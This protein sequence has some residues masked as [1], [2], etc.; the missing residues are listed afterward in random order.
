MS[1]SSSS[2]SS[3]SNQPLERQGSS[4]HAPPPPDPDPDRSTSGCRLVRAAGSTQ[5]QQRRSTD[6]KAAA[7]VGA[8]KKQRPRTVHPPPPPARTEHKESVKAV[9]GLAG[10]SPSR[11]II[12]PPS[13]WSE[14]HVP[15]RG[16]PDELIVLD[17]GTMTGRRFAVEVFPTDTI[18]EVKSAIAHDQG[19]PAE[20]QVLVHR[21]KTLRDSAMVYEYSLQ[22]GARVDLILS[23]AGGHGPI[24]ASLHARAPAP[25]PPPPPL[26]SRNYDNEGEDGTAPADG[27]SVLLLLCRQEDDL[28]LL[29]LLMDRGRCVDARAQYLGGPEVSPDDLAQL[30]RAMGPAPDRGGAAP[31]SPSSDP[32][33]D[34]VVGGVDLAQLLGVPPRPA[35]GTGGLVSSGDE[36]PEVLY[37]DEEPIECPPD[38]SRTSSAT[39]VTAALL[40]HPPS[41]VYSSISTQTPTTAPARSARA[42]RPGTADSMVTLPDDIAHQFGI[43]VHDHPR[44]LA[45]AISHAVRRAQPS[46][47]LPPLARGG[48]V[49]TR[50][51]RPA[52]AITLTRVAVRPLSAGP[53]AFKVR[54]ASA[55]AAG[56][57]KTVEEEDVARQTDDSPCQVFKSAPAVQHRGHLPSLRRLHHRR[58]RSRNGRPQNH[59][60]RQ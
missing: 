24:A 38:S 20:S 31:G 51:A 21:S 7:V 2:S 16:N 47:L 54:A 13:I 37:D 48:S 46:W 39:T 14:A 5:Q 43:P 29:E 53:A 12:T 35:R 50:A 42:A 3:S 19:V 11:A 6:G 36:I 44:D 60:P 32:A 18:W 10:L 45:A 30:I 58:S 40:S 1:N 4:S 23:L 34:T 49:T 15:F 28:Y 55:P 59:R 17:V 26:L 57:G 9:G 22:S 25:P 27:S 8:G 56:R 52:T 33:G 41:H